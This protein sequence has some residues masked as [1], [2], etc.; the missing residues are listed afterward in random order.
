MVEHNGGDYATYLCNVFHDDPE[1]QDTANR[2]AQEE[3]QHG[4]ALARWAELADPSST[5][6]TRSGASPRATGCRWRRP[7]PC[8]AA[9]RAS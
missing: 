1:F 6:R 2:W 5:S 8:A 3:V 9:A 4:E 7:S